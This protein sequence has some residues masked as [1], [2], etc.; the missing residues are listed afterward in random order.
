MT[1][2]NGRDTLRQYYNAA[3]SNYADK[4]SEGFGGWLRKREM[5]L[6]L[7][8]IPDEGIGRNTLDAGCGPALYS[9]MLRERGFNVTAVDISPEMVAI[10]K[11]LGFPAHEMDI[12]H[13]TPPEELPMPFDFILCA[14]VLEFA[15]DVRGFLSSL[16]SLACDEGEIVLI[17]PLAG[18]MGFF[19]RN[20]LTKRGIPARV[21]TKKSLHLA[22]ESAGFEPIEI[23]VR[24][25]I[26]L[27][28][29]AKA[30]KRSHDEGL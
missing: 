27:A 8:L 23:K 4:M 29:R 6:T 22:L 9:M 25:P 18:T 2:N 17:A 24:W 12:E 10:A 5:K 26:C 21:Y 11:D 30:A 3:A 13:S 19:Y 16:R 20:Y 15:D 14:G 28:A 1:N 7:E